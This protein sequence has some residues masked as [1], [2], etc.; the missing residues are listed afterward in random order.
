MWFGIDGTPNVTALSAVGPGNS[1]VSEFNFCSNFGRRLAMRDWVMSIEVG[2]HLPRE[3]IPQFV[4][5]LVKHNRFGIV[6]SWA[7]HNQLGKGHISPKSKTEVNRLLAVHGYE[8][9]INA[10]APLYRMCD[11][12]L[13]AMNVQVFRPVALLAQMAS[14]RAATFGNPDTWTLD[15]HAE[16]T[17]C[18]RKQR[19]VCSS[20]KDGY[21][22]GSDGSRSIRRCACT[23]QCTCADGFRAMPQL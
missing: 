19:Q 6:L 1:V 20:D 18:W 5:L 17:L 8:V 10:T 2:E 12:H 11:M 23:A 3:C 9:D 21:L 16:S 22:E 15:R 4:Q 14:W 7:H 13:I